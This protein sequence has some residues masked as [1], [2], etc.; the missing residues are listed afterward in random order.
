MGR[1]HKMFDEIITPYFDIE[2]ELLDEHNSARESEDTTQDPYE[3]TN[4]PHL[5]LEEGH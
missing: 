1:E 3:D 4:D 2:E 5:I